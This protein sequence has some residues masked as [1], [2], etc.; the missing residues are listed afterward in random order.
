MEK[1]SRKRLEDT[2]AASDS[3]EEQEQKT[4]NLS[5]IS[6]TNFNFKVR[7]FAS[8]NNANST[9]GT[10]ISLYL[11]IIAFFVVLN[12]VSNQSQ[13]KMN[14]VEES[15]ISEFYSDKDIEKSYLPNQKPSIKNS[16]FN[17]EV[18]TALSS[19]IGFDYHFPTGDGN[20]IK[21]SFEAK[22]LFIDK[23]ITFKSNQEAFLKQLAL[24]LKREKNYEKREIEFVVYTG[25]K[26]PSGSKLW[27][28]INIL[29][30]GAFVSKIVKLGGRVDQ[31]SMG[32]TEGKRN[33]ISLIFHTRDR[34]KA[35][36]DLRKV[37]LSSTQK[38][39]KST[40]VKDKGEYL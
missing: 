9:T 38:N 2:H 18:K 4:A 11:I 20:V 16:D 5:R 39:I 24:F 21:V 17:Y 12:S 14:D 23:K 32:V 3:V 31:L 28:D 34:K 37:A 29:R 30:S 40:K 27:Q 26:L 1:N 36:Q 6:N 25:S 22:K 33:F 10:F 8:K 15:L 13:T 35:R 7:S 19:L